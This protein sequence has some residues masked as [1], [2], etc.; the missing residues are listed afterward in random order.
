MLFPA[1]YSFSRHFF[2]RCY[3]LAVMGG[4]FKSFRAFPDSH[5]NALLACPDSLS[6][7]NYTVIS[8]ARD[9][10]KFFLMIPGSVYWPNKN[11]SFVMLASKVMSPVCSAPRVN[12]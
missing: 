8:P 3:I 9:F 5:E 11:I 7:L 2:I 10:V 1:F 12:N 4:I 6:I